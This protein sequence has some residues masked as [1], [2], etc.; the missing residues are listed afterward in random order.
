LALDLSARGA[1]AESG[2][3][4]DDGAASFAPTSAEFDPGE[5]QSGD[6]DLHELGRSWADAARIGDAMHWASISQPPQPLQHG[7]SAVEVS[8]IP[9]ASTGG[10]VAI[11]IA[12]ILAWSYATS[13]RKHGLGAADHD[14]V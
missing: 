9:E 7:Y 14:A 8:A 2:L 10:S 12:S 13:R 1:S 3:T 11:A 6:L 5:P 4:Q